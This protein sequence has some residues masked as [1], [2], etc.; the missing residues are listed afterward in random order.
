MVVVV[1]GTKSIPVSCRF[2]DQRRRLLTLGWTYFLAA[3]CQTPGYRRRTPPG[4]APGLRRIGLRVVEAGGGKN[5]PENKKARFTE[6]EAQEIDSVI[7]G[8]LR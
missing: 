8:A 6:G 4:E 2:S 1:G 3:C 5:R 7:L